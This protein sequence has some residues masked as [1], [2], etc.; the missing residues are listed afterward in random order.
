MIPGSLSAAS[1]WVG[2]RQEIYSAINTQSPVKINLDHYIVDR[3]FDSADDDAWTNR[4]VVNLADVINFCFADVP[5]SNARWIYL[6]EQ[7]MRWEESRPSA[8][9]PFF[10]REGGASGVFPEVWHH[11]SCHGKPTSPSPH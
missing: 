8:F 4:A 3:S 10:F 6:N 2:L 1:Y 9:E 5:P 11:S 7:C